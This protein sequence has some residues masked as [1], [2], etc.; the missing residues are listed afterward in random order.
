VSLVHSSPP[1]RMLLLSACRSTTTPRRGGLLWSGRAWNASRK[2][3][4]ILQSRRH[5]SD[6]AKAAHA[7]RVEVNKKMEAKNLVEMNKKM[8]TLSRETKA[9]IVEMNLKMERLSKE[10]EGRIGQLS[11]VALSAL[12]IAVQCLF[13]K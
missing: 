5:S 12:S 4:V 10:T 11:L 13:L 6:E 2:K 8:D 3:E 9:S 7:R 1:R